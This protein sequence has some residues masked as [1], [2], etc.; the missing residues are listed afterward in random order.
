[1]FHASIPSRPAVP[2]GPS[3]FRLMFAAWVEHRRLARD[4]ERL[5]HLPD[6]LLDDLGLTR[7]GRRQP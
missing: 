6:Y 3:L 4:A 2:K 5:R 7:D 1:M